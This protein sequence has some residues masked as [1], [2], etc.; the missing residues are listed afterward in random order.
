MEIFGSCA[1]SV[2]SERTKV[3]ILFHLAICICIH[4]A[5]WGCFLSARKG[6]PLSSHCIALNRT[7]EA[8]YLPT[9]H[10][11]PDSPPPE[12]GSGEVICPLPRNPSENPKALEPGLGAPL[13][14]S[15]CWRL[16]RASRNCPAHPEWPWTPASH[17]QSGGQ[18]RKPRIGRCL[19]HRD[20]PASALPHPTRLPS[21]SGCRYQIS[22]SVQLPSLV[23]F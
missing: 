12:G 19:A 7:D 6:R 8:S 23:L 22:G 5:S 21:Y 13:G 11:L 4:N 9:P 10:T 1:C 2:T 17:P 20:P 15:R 18:T 3:Y 16:A 14:D